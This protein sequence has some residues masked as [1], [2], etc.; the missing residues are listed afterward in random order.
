MADKTINGRIQLKHDTEANW[1][2]LQTLF[3]NKAKLSLFLKAV[4]E[5][6]AIYWKPC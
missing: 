3:Q 2:N 4:L 5:I 1:L 6:Q